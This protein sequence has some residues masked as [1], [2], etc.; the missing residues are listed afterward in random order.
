[1]EAKRFLPWKFELRDINGEG[2]RPCWVQV[3]LL[4]AVIADMRNDCDCSEDYCNNECGGGNCHVKDLTAALE[5][6][7]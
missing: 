1:M 7:K 3:E 2:D 4:E 5:V 6:G